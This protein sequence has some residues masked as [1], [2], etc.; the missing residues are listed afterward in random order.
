MV[1][2]SGADLVLPD[3]VLAA[4]ALVLVDGRIADIRAERP[5]ASAASTFAFHGHTIVPGFIDLHVHGVAGVDVHDDPDAV[6]RIAT[7]LPRFGVTAFSPTTVACSPSA[8]TQVLAQVRQLRGTPAA[9]GARVLPA[10]LESNF[11]NPAFAGAQPGSC[12]RAWPTADA[13]AATAT[14]GLT[15]FSA[16]ELLAVIQEYAADV[17]IVTLAPELAGALDRIAWLGG[18]G[19]RVSLG[20]SGATYAEAMAAIAVG[21]TLAT[22]LFNR[23]P[24]L[25]HREPGLA[26]AVLEHDDIVVELI[27]DGVH[28]HPAA[29]RL[30]IAAKRPS[31]VMA[32][33]DGTAA[34]A[35]PPG[36]RVHLGGQLIIADEQCARLEDGTMAGSVLTMD[37]AFRKLTGSFGVSLVDAATLCATTPAR[38]LGLSGQ[39]TLTPGAVADL[40]V[41]DREGEVVQTYVAGRLV[42]SRAVHTMNSGSGSAV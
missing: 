19:I 15:A 2:L 31:H 11:I 5:V 16:T 40:V 26:G 33:S 12:L 35:M 29:V 34:A 23:M 10:H 17:G 30:A 18:L 28:V 14:R 36:T 9:L 24:P 39:G 22:H 32:I 21:A 8:L 3:R 38:A 27:C 4:G 7:A 37:A 6:E 42:Y 25:H 41:L 1:V 20:H 13:A